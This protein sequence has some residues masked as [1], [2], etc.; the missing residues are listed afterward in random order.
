MDA[1][2]RD[3]LGYPVPQHANPADHAL[4]IFNTDFMTDPAHRE[5]HVLDYARR[6][7]EYAAVH[8][9]AM[10]PEGDKDEHE[11]LADPERTILSFSRRRGLTAGM[12]RGVHRTGILM[13]R[14]V[15]N[16]SRN[17]LAYGV[18]VGMYRKCS[19]CA[20]RVDGCDLT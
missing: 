12:V 15:L 17:L 10:R 3:G 9:L 13:E 16:Y 20:F 14:N 5:A 7:T 18:R 1:Y 8:G 6:W 11:T 4:E 2:L 19:S